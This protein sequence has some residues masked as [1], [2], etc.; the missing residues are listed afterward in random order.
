MGN[1]EGFDHSFGHGFHNNIGFLHPVLPCKIFSSRVLFCIM[2]SC[3]P[4]ITGAGRGGRGAGGAAA[5][6]GLRVRYIDRNDF[7]QDCMFLIL[8]PPGELVPLAWMQQG[9]QRQ[10]Q[11]QAWLPQ[12]VPG[13]PPSTLYP[14]SQI[15]AHLPN[16]LRI[17]EQFS[18]R[19]GLPAPSHSSW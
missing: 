16:W 8:T 6:R 14:P 4:A 1:L 17:L 12:H 9:G 10:G 15:P 11:E 18:S 3:S 5:C 19:Q 2:M 7:D 13:C